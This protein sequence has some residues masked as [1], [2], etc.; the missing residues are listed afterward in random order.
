MD[1]VLDVCDR[2][3]LM[4]GGKILKTGD[5]KTIVDDLTPTEKEKMLKEE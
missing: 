2:A 5:P 3:S 4:R 1:F